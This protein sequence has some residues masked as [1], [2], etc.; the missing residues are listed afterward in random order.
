MSSTD[1]SNTESDREHVL[2]EQG[3]SDISTH[4]SNSP[5]IEATVPSS[6]KSTSIFHL[7]QTSVIRKRSVQT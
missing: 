5:L 4:S 7:Y 6:Q 3:D 1:Q 2:W